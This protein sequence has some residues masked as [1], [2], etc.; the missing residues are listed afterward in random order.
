VLSV[1]GVSGA[2]S[3]SGGCRFNPRP[4]CQCVVLTVPSSPRRS[5][6]AARRQAAGPEAAPEE[7]VHPRPAGLQ[8]DVRLLRAALHSPVLQVR[9]EERT[10]LH[11]GSR[12][13]GR[14]QR[15][16]VQTDW[17]QVVVF[18]FDVLYRLKV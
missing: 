1:S 17:F 9:H 8:P 18:L 15:Q 13:R 2:V 3:Q 14:R 5:Q 10:G 6:G 11:S 12:A 16:T 7:G 4:R